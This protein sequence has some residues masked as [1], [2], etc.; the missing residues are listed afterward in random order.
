[1]S[2]LK[3]FLNKKSFEINEE[4]SIK[5]IDINDLG[6]FFWEREGQEWAWMWDYNL[7]D[8]ILQ[9]EQSFRK[10][11]IKAQDFLDALA[12]LGED[13]VKELIKKMEGVEK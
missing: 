2:D 5:V 1:M 7:K 11:D 12:C 3:E 6:L 4:T 10:E 9:A 13:K 8:C